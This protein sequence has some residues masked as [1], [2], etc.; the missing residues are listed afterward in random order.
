MFISSI[1]ILYAFHLF[2]DDG[3]EDGGD[4]GPGKSGRV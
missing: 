3:D 1:Y 2:Q 4:E